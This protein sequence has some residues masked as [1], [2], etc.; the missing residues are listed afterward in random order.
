VLASAAARLYFSEKGSKQ[1]KRLK[2]AAAFNLNCQEDILY[3]SLVDLECKN[4]EW[5]QEIYLDFKYHRDSENFYSFEGDKGMIG[6]LFANS[7]EAQEFYEVVCDSLEGYTKEERM[8]RNKVKSSKSTIFGVFGF[9]RK[10]KSSE[11]TERIETLEIKSKLEEPKK[12]KKSKDSELSHDD[13]SEPR[14]F[15]HLSHIGFNP[16]KGTFD[17]QNIPSDWK[18]LFAKAGITQDQL[19]NRSTAKFI[20]GFVQDSEP[21]MQEMMQKKKKP[22]VPVPMKKKNAPPPPPPPTKTKK[23][24]LNSPLKSTNLPPPPP[25]KKSNNSSISKTSVSAPP[26]PP[27][28]LPV[29]DIA[30]IPQP[31]VAPS[32]HSALLESIRGAGTSVLKPVKENSVPKSS[33]STA[34]SCADPH[35]VLMAS[36]KNGASLKPASKASPS[37]P[38][39]SVSSTDP[40]DMMAAMLAK[41]LAARNKKLAADSSDEDE[42]DSDDSRW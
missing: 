24:P 35:S 22:P 12:K 21:Q 34:P 28:P 16:E 10:S 27:P 29:P 15:T 30:S 14:D 13:V 33:A 9:G 8:S 36:I 37:S 41:A 23:Q 5:S 40:T 42:N 17:I 4:L 32:V 19:Q 2:E 7:Q 38:T 18:T 11:S 26:P 39:S 31:A 1:W 25:P 20:A 3:F 6:I